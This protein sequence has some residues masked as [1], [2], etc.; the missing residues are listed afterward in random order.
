MCDPQTH[1]CADG[2]SAE[3]G[4]GSDSSG[5]GGDATSSCGSSGAWTVVPAFTQ[6][7]LNGIWGTATS[8]VW[9]SGASLWHWDASA[10]SQQTSPVATLNAAVVWTGAP[11]DLWLAD[12]EHAVHHW[13]NHAWATYLPND[14]RSIDHLWGSSVSD[15]WG[16]DDAAGYSGHWD[17]ATWSHVDSIPSGAIWGSGPKDVWTARGC[18][19]P[20]CQGG[21]FHW[22]GG[23]YWVGGAQASMKYAIW[24]SAANDIWAVGNGNA[25][26]YDGSAWSADMALPTTES[27]FGVWGSAPCDVWAVGAG[28]VILHFDGTAWSAAT[29]PTTVSLQAVW[30]S[31]TGDVWAVGAGGTVLHWR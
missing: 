11:N 18:P 25:I 24:G 1:V 14:N 19:T 23:P 2:G 31:G 26:H 22:T 28:G 7:G 20:E 13:T 27:L 9:V 15:V 30:G 16:T 10:W 3:A 29:S 8:D 6:D 5:P 12:G 4:P 21:L 17:G